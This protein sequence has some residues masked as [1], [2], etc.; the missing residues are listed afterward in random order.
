[1]E[2]YLHTTLK[3]NCSFL[4]E[5]KL[6]VVAVWSMAYTYL[7]YYYGNFAERYRHP[8]E[9]KTS[10]YLFENGERVDNALTVT[11]RK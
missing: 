5:E 3:L 2:Q 9:H 1:M 7:H 10:H 6:D 11:K 4:Q 8:S